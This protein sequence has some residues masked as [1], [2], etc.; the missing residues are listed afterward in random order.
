MQQIEIL[1]AE[2]GQYVNRAWQ[3]ERI[4][5]GDQTDRGVN[6]HGANPPLIRIRLQDIPLYDGDSGRSN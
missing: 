4:W 5:N 3:S 2:E 1:S 6:F